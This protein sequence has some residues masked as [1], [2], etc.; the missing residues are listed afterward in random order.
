MRAEWEKGGDRKSQTTQIIV[1]TKL[2]KY[3]K[4]KIIPNIEENIYHFK[5][6]FK[7]ER[8]EKQQTWYFKRILNPLSEILGARCVSE[9]R[10]VRF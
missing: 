9:F 2:V 5:E 8:K 3:F 10:V 7:K 6:S 4:I 1:Q